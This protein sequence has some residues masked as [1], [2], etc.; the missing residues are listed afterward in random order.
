MNFH[1]LWPPA[2]EMAA[3]SVLS[4][5]LLRADCRVRLLNYIST[6]PID[7]PVAVVFGHPA[8]L[9][10]TGPGFAR[11]GL[12]VSDELWKAGYYADL[13]PSSEIRS[14]A[15]AIGSDGRM[16]YGPQ[17]YAALV[18]VQPQYERPEMAAFFRK[19]S[20]RGRTALFRVGDWTV[21]FEGRA[22]EGER[23]LPREMQGVDVAGC[24]QRVIAALKSWGI[25]PQTPCETHASAGFP[26]SAMPR[27]RGQCRLLD[28]TVILASGEKDVMGDRIR[29][30]LRVAGH[31]VAFDAVGVAAVR[32]DKSGKVAALAAGGLK[33]F[34]AGNLVI[35]LRERADVALWREARGP[36]QG[37]LQGHE[38]P[39][40]EPLLK[41][42]PKWTRLRLPTPLD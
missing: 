36:W 7:C 15:L 25:E 32:L 31:E 26:G 30:T 38:G 11:V 1:P 33:S 9:N 17:A 13:I 2:P 24:A 14:G 16:R 12:E 40:P 39:V 41:L 4:G 23:A 10:W 5:N 6:A 28:G 29:T 22:F 18:L 8:A 37:I 35:E 20:K 21:D 3:T 34:R 19:A 42:T 27:A